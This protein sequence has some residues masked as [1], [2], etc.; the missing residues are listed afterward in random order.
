MR[1]W[2]VAEIK[3][4]LGSRVRITTDLGETH[5]GAVWG[6]SI[7]EGDA[8]DRVLTLRCEGRHD[9][10]IYKSDIRGYEVLP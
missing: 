4:V 5:E 2:P 6:V 9:Q 8:A 7:A 1:R 10:R 3:I